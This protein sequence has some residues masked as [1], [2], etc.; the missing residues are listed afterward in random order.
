MRTGKNDQESTDE[1]ERSRRKM[2][3]ERFKQN[4][5]IRANRKCK[6]CMREN[7]Y[8]RKMSQKHVITNE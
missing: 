4:E 8:E 6:E 3:K 2:K 5:R 7:G 1:E